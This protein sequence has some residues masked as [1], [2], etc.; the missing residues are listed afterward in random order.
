MRRLRPIAAVWLAMAAT[1]LFACGGS[2]DDG[3]DPIDAASGIDGANACTVPTATTSCTVGDDTPCTALC[4]TAYCHNFG[5]LP[6]P[7]CT[8]PCA[9]GSTDQCPSGWS[10]NNLGRCRPP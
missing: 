3:A 8:N 5:Q 1:A 6:T 2:D 7:V 9:V 10:C 4:G